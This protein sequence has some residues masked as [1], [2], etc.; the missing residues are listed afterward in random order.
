MKTANMNNLILQC[1]IPEEWKDLLSNVQN[2]FPQTF[3]AGGSLRDLDYGLEPK[4]LDIFIPATEK[5]L[6]SRLDYINKQVKSLET[7]FSLNLKDPEPIPEHYLEGE[8]NA[9]NLTIE[10]SY[11]LE[12]VR[13]YNRGNR[14]QRKLIESRKKHLNKLPR[15]IYHLRRASINNYPIDFI[16]GCKNACDIKQFDL[17]FC[18]ISFDGKQIIKT[19]PYK[20]TENSGIV[21]ITN[22]RTYKQERVDK[23]KLKFPEL[24]FECL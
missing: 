6:F 24:K 7:V 20:D 5:T 11:K 3:I 13:D 8:L 21:T 10:E 16:F 17:S 9:A 23:F 2:L 18:Q 22:R 4:D 15:K 14:T 12:S 1:L 19:E